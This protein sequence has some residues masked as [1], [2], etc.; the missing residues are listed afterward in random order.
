VLEISFSKELQ[1]SNPVVPNPCTGSTPGIPLGSFGRVY[2]E[3]G[4]NKLV[5][6]PEM[7][8]TG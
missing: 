5:E 7:R 2:R 3:V 6:C 4:T 1:K 8:V